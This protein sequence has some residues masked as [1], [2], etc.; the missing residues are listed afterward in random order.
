SLLH[1]PPSSRR[2]SAPPPKRSSDQHHRLPR[3]CTDH[4]LS[5]GRR[6]SLGVPTVGARTACAW[7]PHHLARRREPPRPR[8]PRPAQADR[9]PEEP[10]AALRALGIGR[11]LLRRRRAAAPRDCTGFARSRRRR[12]GGP[13]RQLVALPSRGGAAALRPD[14]L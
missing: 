12:R 1:T 8:R 10:V 2:R 3:S 4:P 13:A 5:A 6:P 11:A 14:G 9:R 7:L